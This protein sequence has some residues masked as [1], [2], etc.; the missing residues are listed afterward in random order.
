MFPR[1]YSSFSGSKSPLNGAWILESIFNPLEDLD[2]PTIRSPLDL[3]RAPPIQ[4]LLDSSFEIPNDIIE[5]YHESIDPKEIVELSYS[6][7][8]PP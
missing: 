2:A 6:Q 3:Q 7:S 5:I 4:S 1:S 8:N